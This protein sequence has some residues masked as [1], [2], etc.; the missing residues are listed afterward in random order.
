MTTEH[1]DR[2]IAHVHRYP[3][4]YLHK[5]A[6]QRATKRGIEF[7][8]TVDDVIVPS[9]CPILGVKLR[10]GVGR[11]GRQGGNFD[12]PSLDRKDPSRGYVPGNVMVISHL[13]NTMKQAATNEQLVAFA[14]WVLSRP[15]LVA[16]A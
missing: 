4:R 3:N 11:S 15:E 7:T 8:I 5:I 6:R 16:G 1:T 13:A 14:K 12:S 10:V 9:Y 2:R